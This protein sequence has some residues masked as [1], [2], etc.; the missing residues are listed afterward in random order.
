[1]ESGVGRTRVE[2]PDLFS[3]GLWM[4]A[5]TVGWGAAVYWRGLPHR[6]RPFAHLPLVPRADPWSLADHIARAGG[7]A[8]EKAQT[9]RAGRPLPVVWLRPPRHARP[10][11]RVR[12]RASGAGGHEGGGMRRVVRKAVRAAV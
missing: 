3:S 12:G 6:V 1:M 2:S 11:P 10:V 7:M 5:D 8:G 9:S 4:G